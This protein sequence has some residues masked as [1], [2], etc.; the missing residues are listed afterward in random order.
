MEES[1][2]RII[3]LNHGRVIAE[4]SVADIKRKAAPTSLR[5]RVAPEGHD[6]ALEALA[7]AAGVVVVDSVD[8]K[9]DVFTATFDPAWLDEHGDAGMNSAIRALT[10]AEVPVISFELEGGR[11]SDAFLALTKESPE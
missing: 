6:T 7:Q 2:S 5:V 8:G 4:G 10:D 9:T 11:L 3:I 1:C